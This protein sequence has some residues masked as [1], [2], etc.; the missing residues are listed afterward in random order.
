MLI[1]A[2][3]KFETL[4]T[5]KPVHFEEGTMTIERLKQELVQVS[6]A[7]AESF[8]RQD[9]AGIAAL[10][11]DGGVH[12]NEAGPRN[13][14][15]QLYQAAFKAGSSNHMD[16][17]IDAVWSLGTDIATATGQVHMTGKDQSGAAFERTRRSTG[18]YMREGGIW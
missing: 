1:S 9:A 8:N 15:E 2:T 12:V 4:A 13:D 6:N 16:A 10:F 14:I 18:T 11:V 17:S 3:G 5:G 7:Y